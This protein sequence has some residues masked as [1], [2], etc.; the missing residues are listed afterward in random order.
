MAL[1]GMGDSLDWVD[2][3]SSGYGFD[4]DRATFGRSGSGPVVPASLSDRNLAKKSERNHMILRV[5]LFS[6]FTCMGFAV[7]NGA[8]STYTGTG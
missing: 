3:W 1:S 8:I 4:H 2:A 6:A 7:L 5:M